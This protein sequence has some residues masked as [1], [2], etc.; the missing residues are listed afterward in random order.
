MKKFN[1]LLLIIPLLLVACFSPPTPDV[2][3]A[4]QNANP[5]TVIPLSGE[6]TNAYFRT[7]LPFVPSPTRGLIW[8]HIFNRADILQVEMSLMRI[9]TDFFDPEIYYI[10]EGQHLTRDFV[11]DLLRH[12][13]PNPEPE[14]RGFESPRGLNP[15]IGANI[16]FG[17]RYLENDSQ[18]LIR[19]FAYVVEQNFV[20]ISEDHQFELEGVAIAIAL[21][22]FHLEIDTSI[23]FE[24]WHQMS[25]ED[26]LEFGKEIAAD[27]LL[28]LRTADDVDGLDEVPILIGLYILR[29]SQSVIPGHFSNMTYIAAGRS[30]I[31]EWRDVHER[32]FSLV[33]ST[34]HIYAY[35]VDIREQ[36]NLFKDLIDHYFPHSHHI[37]GNVHFVDNRVYRVTI[38]VNMYFLG[39]TEKISFFQ[40]LEEHIMTFSREFDV[41]IMVR[42]FETQLGAV[43]RPSN[44]EVAV[45]LLDW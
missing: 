9:A 40:L 15:E 1:Y 4:I 44:G 12:Q 19:P 20:T 43:N 33:D 24:Y 23:G 13:N 29:S 45:H 32:H 28:Y 31:R 37:I 25:D 21:N 2:E 26:I 7:A 3:E 30:S 14:N 38:T 27:L 36:F 22:P 5:E 41:R 11:A 17:D 18:D 39:A 8:G 42:N 16:P 10:R 6:V 34:D 35:N